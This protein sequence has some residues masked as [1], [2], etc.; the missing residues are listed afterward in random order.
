MGALNTLIN[1]YK[2]VNDRLAKIEA[3]TVLLKAQ[4]A[5]LLAALKRRNYDPT[6][7]PPSSGYKHVFTPLDETLPDELLD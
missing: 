1:E 5:G 2:S 6:K 4:R 3:E 7:T